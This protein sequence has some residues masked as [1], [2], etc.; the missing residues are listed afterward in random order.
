MTSKEEE[1]VDED[2]I[3]WRAQAKQSKGKHC[4]LVRAGP[5]AGQQAAAGATVRCSK[6]LSFFLLPSILRLVPKNILRQRTSLRPS[7]GL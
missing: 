3:R 4:L 6:D 2:W 7:E 1:T 5:T